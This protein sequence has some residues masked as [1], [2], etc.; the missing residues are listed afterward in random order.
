[1]SHKGF[2][3]ATALRTHTE[4]GVQ[5]GQLPEA[6]AGTIG[7]RVL[8]MMATKLTDLLQPLPVDDEYL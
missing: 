7:S 2:T 3:S 6:F 1:M 4:Y 8:L 5:R